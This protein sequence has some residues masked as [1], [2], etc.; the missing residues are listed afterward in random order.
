MRQM[1]EHKSSLTLIGKTANANSFINLT[2][3]SPG[4]DSITRIGTQITMT[5]CEVRFITRVP[6]AP[7]T[8]DY[9]CNWVAVLFT[10]LD[11]T[12][13]TEDTLF[14]PIISTGAAL[15]PIKPQVP[16]NMEH[17]KQ[18][19]IWWTKRWTSDRFYNPVGNLYL[20]TQNAGSQIEVVMPLSNKR[21]KN[22][23]HFNPGANSGTNQLYLYIGNS[24]LGAPT[25]QGSTCFGIARVTFVDM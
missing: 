6:D 21:G 25:N 13:P 16:F 2:L 19:K 20:T 1:C 14:D 3:I 4:F 10:W 18:R 15:L 22:I 24:D 11:D 5:S 12:T 17:K 23:V 9:Q 7:A 8:M